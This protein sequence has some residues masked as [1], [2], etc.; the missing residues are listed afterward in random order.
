MN[1]RYEEEKEAFLAHYGVPGM[2]WGKRKLYSP[3]GS[4]ELSGKEA[5]AVRKDARNTARANKQQARFNKSADKGDKIASK[6]GGNTNKAFGRELGKAAAGVVLAEAGGRIAMKLA[7]TPQ[8]AIGIQLATRLTQA[9][10]MAV[11]AS[12][13]GNLNDSD[14][15]TN[16]LDS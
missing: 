8:A 7:R 2:R 4:R 10:V 9:G 12:R 1:D 15:R 5:R 6:T 11:S 13:L 14:D 16:P 3:D